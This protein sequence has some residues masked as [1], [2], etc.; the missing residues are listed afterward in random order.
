MITGYQPG[1]IEMKK[2]IVIPVLMSGLI[3]F[4][5]LNQTPKPCEGKENEAGRVAVFPFQDMNQAASE[6]QAGK[7]FAGLLIQKLKSRLGTRVL[8]LSELETFDSP[9]WKPDF[10]PADEDVLALASTINAQVLIFGRVEK[11]DSDLFW[12]SRAVKGCDATL[13]WTETSQISNFADLEAQIRALE[14]KVVTVIFTD[15]QADSGMTEGTVDWMDGT[16]I[17][18]TEEW[19]P[20][21]VEVVIEKGKIVSIRI[22]EDKGT[23]EFSRLAAETLPGIMIAEGRADVDGVT[24]ATL[25]SNSLKKAVGSALEKAR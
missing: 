9:E 18:E 11:R 5:V 23:P 10:I 20:I 8:D 24:G 15:T 13:M 12:E 3:V 25:S 1:Y 22:L 14:E 17:G 4:M 6:V 19:P 7:N 2:R 21:K 16:Y